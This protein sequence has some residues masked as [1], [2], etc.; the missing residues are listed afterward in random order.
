MNMD[1]PELIENICVLWVEQLPI[2]GY[3]MKGV[4]DILTSRL[5]KRILPNNKLTK[6]QKRF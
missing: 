2:V 6:W 1:S 3:S 4:M 5:A